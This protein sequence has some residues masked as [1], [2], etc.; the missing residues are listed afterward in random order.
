MKIICLLVYTRVSDGT[1]GG[2]GGNTKG[3]GVN[4][5]TACQGSADVDGGETGGQ[6]VD[7]KFK[8]EAQVREREDKKEYE[9]VCRGACP[10]RDT[11]RKR[12]DMPENCK[13][14]VAAIQ[15]ADNGH[16]CFRVGG[17]EWYVSWG[18][19]VV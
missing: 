19:E 14:V 3:M 10:G 13:A 17:Q 16:Y 15:N 18:V 9:E 7:P 11:M 4:T 1:G 2:N 8:G 6:R 5:K 12:I